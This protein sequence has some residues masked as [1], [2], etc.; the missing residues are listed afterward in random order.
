MLRPG[1]EV[2]TTE[3]LR[4]GDVIENPRTEEAYPITVHEP[5]N[6]RFWT[7]HAPPFY[8]DFVP[9]WRLHWVRTGGG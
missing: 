2:R 3:E 5:R 1:W 9:R 8:W 7:V 4:V 6:E